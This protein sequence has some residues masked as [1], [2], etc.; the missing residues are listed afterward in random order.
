MPLAHC[1]I[2]KNYFPDTVLGTESQE[3]NKKSSFYY[4]LRTI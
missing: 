4:K 3:V 2:K 1:A